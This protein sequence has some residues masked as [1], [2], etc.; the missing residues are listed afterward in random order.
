MD[1][2][3][4]RDPRLARQ[5][6]SAPQQQQQQ[7]Q[8]SQ[9]PP[10]QPY[11]QQQSG[12]PPPQQ[13]QQQYPPPQYQTPQPH[14]SQQQPQYPH[15]YQ[16][17][18]PSF[19]PNA[20]QGPPYPS[21]QQQPPTAPPFP[22]Q[23]Q[24]TPAPVSA[25]PTATPQQY[26]AH[27]ISNQ[28]LAEEARGAAELAKHH[29]PEP[30]KT[31]YKPR[32]LFCVVCASNQVRA[33][34]SPTYVGRFALIPSLLDRTARWRGTTYSR[35]LFLRRVGGR[36]AWRFSFSPRIQEGWL[37]RRLVWDGLCCAFAWPCDRQAEHIPVRYA[38]QRYLPGAREAGPA[39]VR[40]TP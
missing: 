26:P 32:P 18:P 31:I 13:Y 22:T 20:Q 14:Y 38:V 39:A 34:P 5:R 9:Y 23:S 3:R 24:P 21:Q 8:Q 25:Y 6:G 7:Q 16:Q 15:Q 12:Y 33:A 2:R 1:P 11:Q 19:P 28:Q 36:R 27:A 37:P 4:A 10:Q 35:E 29:D 30:V 17:P 40:F